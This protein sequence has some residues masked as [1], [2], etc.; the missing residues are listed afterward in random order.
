MEYL[1]SL[2]KLGTEDGKSFGRLPLDEGS[3]VTVVIPSRIILVTRTSRPS[4]WA[5]FLIIS[6]I[7]EEVA[8]STPVATPAEEI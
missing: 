3:P 1:R 5:S 2:T 4:G 7:W 8:T 6:S